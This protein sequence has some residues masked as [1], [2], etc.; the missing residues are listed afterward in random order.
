MSHTLRPTL[1]DQPRANRNVLVAATFILVV[2]AFCY[3]NT[4]TA[5]FFFDDKASIEENSSIRH[6][7]D[8]RSVLSPPVTGAG[9]TGRPVVNLSLAI[10]YA[11]SGKSPGGYRATNILLH[12]L[13][14]LTFFGLVRRTLLLPTVPSRFRAATLPL[15]TAIAGLWTLHPL[16]TESVTCIIQRTEIL[17][18]LFYLLTLYAFVRSVDSTSRSWPVVCV[19]SCLIGMASKEVMVSAP[20]MVLLYDR[21]FVAGSFRTAWQRRRALYLC[22]ACTWVLLGYLVLK[23][24]GARGT[25]AG[26]GLGVSWWTYAL[27]QCEAIVWYVWLGLWPHP[28]VVFYGSDV[29]TRITEVWWQIGVLTTAVV[30]TLI[31]LR[32]QP[33]LGFVLLWFFVILAPSSSVIPLITQTMAE[34]RMYLPLASVLTLLVLGVYHLAGR[35]ALWGFAAVAT[36]LAFLTVRRNHDYQSPLRIWTDTVAKRP[37]AAQAHVNL[38]AALRDLGR[39]TEALE[40]YEMAVRL[41]PGLS[42]AHNNIATILLETGRPA[43]A[44]AY[45]ETALRLKP[46]FA[47]AHNNLGSALSQ[48]GRLAESDE[49]IRT[50]IRLNPELAPA[51]SNLAGILLRERK[52][53]EAIYHAREA[54]RLDPALVDARANLT[55]AL[56]A[57]GRT[58]ESIEH[59]EAMVRLTPNDAGAWSNLGAAL[60]RL[61]RPREAIPHFQTA[62]RLQPNDVNALN[63]LGSALVQTGELTEAMKYYRASLRMT[64]ENADVHFN[65]GLALLRIGSKSEAAAEFETVLRLNPQHA[66][67]RAALAASR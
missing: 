3:F 51:H 6:L 23:A 44:I 45:C 27:K 37:L 22:L 34:H 38:G 41:A 52:Y 55:S 15:A 33:K 17:V 59:F 60:Y 62:L 20:L 35:H 25:A 61:G 32:R 46:D 16:Q 54:A 42:E 26:L 28:L 24:G 8:V 66:D 5:P 39:R 1:S 47:I 11:L 12:V 13:T 21:T 63:N 9:V 4:R 50:A 36:S 19:G 10:N 49:H 14:G 57:L 67:A 43:E 2:T 56:L 65:L 29:V 7:M 40:H 64:P 30:A 31:A 58:E 18:G 48:I 53:A